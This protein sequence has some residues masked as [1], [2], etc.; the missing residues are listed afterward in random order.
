VD[1]TQDGLDIAVEISLHESC[2]LDPGPRNGMQSGF[3]VRTES[4]NL[5]E[6]RPV[7]QRVIYLPHKLCNVDIV[8]GLAIRCQDRL[9]GIAGA[10][11]SESGTLPT[12]RNTALV[13]ERE[14]EETVRV[15]HGE[16]VVS[17]SNKETAR[18]QR[19]TGIVM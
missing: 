11:G 10:N 9:R 16:H 7:Q 15:M 13:E 12:Y 19:A 3:D 14:R 5:S 17:G 4:R 18:K 6:D 8:A 2:S 1:G